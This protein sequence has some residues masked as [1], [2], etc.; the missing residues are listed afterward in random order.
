MKI[1]F[2]FIDR[3]GE[4]DE[5]SVDNQLPK[6]LKLANKKEY[7]FKELY[8]GTDD[9]VIA[10]SKENFTIAQGIRKYNQLKEKL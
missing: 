10:Y 7:I 2:I 8:F 4:V 9:M 1:K 5:I 6:L 3:I